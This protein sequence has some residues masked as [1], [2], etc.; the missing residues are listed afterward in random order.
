MKCGRL[1]LKFDDPNGKSKAVISD[2]RKRGDV[3][4]STNCG[5]ISSPFKCAP[6]GSLVEQSLLL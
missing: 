2:L 5:N 6:A 4:S 1:G 3:E